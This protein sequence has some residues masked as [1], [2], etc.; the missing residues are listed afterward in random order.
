MKTNTIIIGIFLVSILVLSGC[1][2]RYVCFNGKTV[3]S[4]SQCDVCG[5]DECTG[6]ETKCNCNED[7]GPWEGSLTIMRS[8]SAAAPMQDSAKGGCTNVM[9]GC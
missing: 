6:E 7:C 1:E 9:G 5:D 3:S 4:A 8:C 2:T